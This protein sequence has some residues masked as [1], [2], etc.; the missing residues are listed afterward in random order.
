MPKIMK[1]CLNLSK[2]WPKYCRSLIFQTR[3]TYQS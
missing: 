2:V 3:C 1:S